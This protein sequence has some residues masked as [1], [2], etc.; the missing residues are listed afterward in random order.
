MY[1]RHRKR[2]Q[3]R[4][5]R[6]DRD[7]HR[8]LPRREDAHVVGGAH[9][10]LLRG[11]RGIRG[12]LPLLHGAGQVLNLEHTFYFPHIKKTIIIII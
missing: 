6:H 7:L 1:Y 2:R 12:G 11:V 3:E 8:L 4:H 10:H 5:P 9:L